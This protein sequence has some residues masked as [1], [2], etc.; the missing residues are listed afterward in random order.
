L[1]GIARVA[2]VSEVWLQ[3]YVNKPDSD[4]INTRSLDQGYPMKV[5]YTESRIKP[6]T[7]CSLTG[8][9]AAEFEALLA[10]LAMPGTN[11]FKIWFRSWI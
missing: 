5:T 1:A 9:R 3:H 10:T 8:L 2:E 4:I 7:L 6:L 11:S